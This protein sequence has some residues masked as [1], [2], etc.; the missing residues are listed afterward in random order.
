[1][2]EHDNKEKNGLDEDRDEIEGVRYILKLFISF[3]SLPQKKS[4]YLLDLSKR[5]KSLNHLVYIPKI[6]Y[7]KK[8]LFRI[9]VSGWKRFKTQKIHISHLQKRMKSHL[10]STTS[11]ASGT[12][13]LCHLIREYLKSHLLSNYYQGLGSQTCPK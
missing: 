8:Y 10:F 11:T 9:Q 2:D 4:S 3:L 5:I 13:N 12:T 6:Y 1:M 7:L